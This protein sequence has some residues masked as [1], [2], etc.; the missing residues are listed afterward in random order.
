V[1]RSEEPINTFPAGACKLCDRWD[2][3][4]SIHQEPY[5]SL[6]AFREHLGY[7]MEQLALFALPKPLDK[8]AKQSS[9]RN[10]E[11]SIHTRDLKNAA[12]LSE[13]LASSTPAGCSPSR[14]EPMEEK[15]SLE[16]RIKSPEP[17]NKNF[18]VSTISGSLSEGKG[19]LEHMKSIQASVSEREKTLSAS[20][21]YSDNQ[22]DKS[23]DVKGSP[24]SFSVT[25]SVRFRG[26]TGPSIKTS[27]Q[28]KTRSSRQSQFFINGDGIEREVITTDICRYLG[29]DAL[30][31]PGIYTVSHAM[32]SFPFTPT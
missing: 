9:S 25:K 18:S 20:K 17:G 30:F 32:N 10:R 15:R 22:T 8:T 2:T 11:E 21:K 16:S 6:E 13:I 26:Q 1:L 14:E 3:I 5:G 29:N 4:L 12:P 31:R 27:S 7:H 19:I 24:T 23:K 28:S